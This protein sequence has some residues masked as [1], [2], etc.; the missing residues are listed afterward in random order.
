MVC[1]NIG[2]KDYLGDLIKIIKSAEFLKQF[3]KVILH[4]YFVSYLTITTSKKFYN[5]FSLDHRFTDDDKLWL[6]FK[7]EPWP[8][9]EELW[10]K[11]REQRRLDIIS[12]TDKTI[13]QILTD[14]PRYKDR[15]GHRLV[16][17][18]NSLNK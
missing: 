5:L 11:T 7:H 12:S 4:I 1:E 8:V 2:S 17:K 3:L 16:K 6:S 9:V 15:D 10:R 18:N 13:A 14:W